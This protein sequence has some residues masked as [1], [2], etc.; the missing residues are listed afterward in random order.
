MPEGNGGCAGGQDSVRHALAGIAGTTSQ[1]LIHDAVRP[2]VSRSV[3]LAVIDAAQRW[4]AAVAG[5]RVRDTV[6]CEGK[7]GFFTSTLPRHLLWDVQT[8]QGFRRE[9][10]EKA[11]QAA[12]RTGYFGTDDASLVER[13]G[14]PVRIVEGSSRNIKITTRDDLVVAELWAK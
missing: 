4:G 13:L 2:L 11:H 9:L 6:K 7:R 1:V 3:I 8:P 10:I 12:K 5:V 14:V